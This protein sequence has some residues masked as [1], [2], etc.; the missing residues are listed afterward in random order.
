MQILIVGAGIGGLTLASALRHT[1][2]SLDLVERSVDFDIPGCGIVLH[3]NGLEALSHLGLADAVCR[4]GNLLLRLEIH[5]GNSALTL[6]L[7]EIWHGKGATFAIARTALHELLHRAALDP[8]AAL[9]ASVRAD[10]TARLRMGCR[11][12]AIESPASRPIAHFDDGSRATYDL[13]VGADG[14]HSAVRSALCP[15]SS[16]VSTDLFYFRFLA[17]N[18]IG[19][20]QDTWV[21]HERPGASYGFIPVGA[22]CLHCFVQV[23]TSVAPCKPEGA[24][25][26]FAQTFLAWSA[27]L[28][29]VFADRSTHVH[30]AFANMVRP[31]TWGDGAC[32]L[33][34]DAAH[35]VSPT[36]SEGGSLAIEDALVLSRA[37]AQSAS[38]SSATQLYRAQR[39][40][41]VAWAHRMALAQTNSLKN[42]KAR[43]APDA[44]VALRHLQQ[45]YRPL[46]QSALP[47]ASS[48]STFAI[49]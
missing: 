43:P 12:V 29:Q 48:L 28:A 30:A 39:R 16:A 35:A 49:D 13:I 38:V 37:L 4:L 14:V 26:Y 31:V 44:E 24:A 11:V 32:A 7:S 5:R 18:S 20:A 40:D 47:D 36:L 10:T 9:G 17:R 34:G 42:A 2:H 1:D 8:S 21:T 6:S 45:V 15:A 41:R 3:P 22:D 23:Q 19:L 46:A 27:E 33:L 25:E